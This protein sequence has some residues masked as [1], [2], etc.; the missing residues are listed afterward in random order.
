[1]KTFEHCAVSIFDMFSTL[2][3]EARDVN[4]YWITWCYIAEE[5]SLQSHCSDNLKILESVD[6]L[7]IS[8]LFL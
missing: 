7:F 4:L 1:M 5:C 2:L 6:Q 8:V 3:V